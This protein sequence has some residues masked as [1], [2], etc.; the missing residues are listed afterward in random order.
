MTRI[1]SSELCTDTVT[2]PHSMTQPLLSTYSKLSLTLHIYF[3]FFQF[4]M[5]YA[6]YVS[7]LIKRIWYG[8]VW[9]GSS[10]GSR[11]K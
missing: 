3:I 8:M 4:H 2:N 6:A 9:Y 11:L 5:L 1:S 10:M 7:Y